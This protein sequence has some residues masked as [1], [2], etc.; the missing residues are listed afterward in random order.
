MVEHGI[1]PSG[2][3][4]D[5]GDVQK[6]PGEPKVFNDASLVATLEGAH[7]NIVFDGQADG[8]VVGTD[9]VLVDVG[10]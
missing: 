10:G 1:R 2:G 3:D 6:L 9:E 4:V 7:G 8:G 5:V